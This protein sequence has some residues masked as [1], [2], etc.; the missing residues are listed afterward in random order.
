MA[1]IAK[2][3]AFAKGKNWKQFLM[4]NSAL[5]TLIL[6]IIVGIVVQG[7][8]FLNIN[9]FIN[10]LFNNAIV[11]IIALGMTLI[12]ISG[13]IDLSVGSAAALTGLLALTTINYTGSVFLGVLVAF[14]AGIFMGAFN[15]ILISKF[16]IPAFIVTLGAMQ[17]FRSLSLHQWQGGGVL[18]GR[19]GGVL[20]EGINVEGFRNF[21]NI[22]FF[23]DVFQGG[24]PLPVLYWIALIILMTLFCK[25]TA[26][27][28]HIYAVGSNER[29]SS[30]S[31]V[32]VK[33]VK[34]FVYMIS[35]A[36]VGFAALVE[37][38]RLGSMNSATSGNLYELQAIAAVIIGGTA[39]SGGRGSM[40][41]T[42]FGTL[43]LGVINNVMNLSG[44]PSFLVGAIQGG[45]VILAVLL[46]M[47]VSKESKGF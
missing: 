18:L 22:R 30:L 17:I 23:T 32:K 42:F 15:G 44:L 38:S 40:L 5:A 10:I 37:A 41:G 1:K 16:R 25:K 3:G 13:G 9:N 45:I 43:T 19:S 35:G 47:G 2:A 21:S 4:D 6:L 7:T 26:L 14:G 12:I 11:G 29:A 28:R 31:A 24:L 34:I 8:T 46:Q 27:G 39:M 36:L 33:R 20:L